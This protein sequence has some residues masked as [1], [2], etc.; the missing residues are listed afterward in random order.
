MIDTREKRAAEKA[1]AQESETDDR[2]VG[3]Q[4]PGEPGGI[5]GGL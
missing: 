1:Q 4:G 5:T 3:S 2:D